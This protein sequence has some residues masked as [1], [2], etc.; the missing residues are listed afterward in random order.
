M[1]EKQINCFCFTISLYITHMHS[2]YFGM[3]YL[4]EYN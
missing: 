3:Y 1:E 4:V 2:S